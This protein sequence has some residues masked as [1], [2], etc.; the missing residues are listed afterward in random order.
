[1]PLSGMKAK[2]S[3]FDPTRHPEPIGYLESKL[4]TLRE[5][6]A[7]TESLK[8]KLDHQDMSVV[9]RLLDQ[10]QN[11]IHIIDQMEKEVQEIRP[12][13]LLNN[14]QYPDEIREKVS[15]LLKTVEDVIRRI[16][17]LDQQCINR[18]TSWRSE[19]RGELQKIQYGLKAVEFYSEKTIRQPRFLDLRR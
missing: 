9:I 3:P 6:L 8:T 17:I 15:T 10:R 5:F 12:G 11:L 7:I 14:Q 19:I 1:M 2:E 4:H 13:N 16:E 18:I